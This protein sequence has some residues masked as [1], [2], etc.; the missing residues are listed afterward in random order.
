[1]L[2][3]L[4][5]FSLKLRLHHHPLQGN[6][7]LLQAVSGHLCASLCHSPATPRCHR[8]LEPQSF[9]PVEAPE[10]RS[11]L[12]HPCVPKCWTMVLSITAR[13]HLLPT[14]RLLLGTAG[15]CRPTARELAE[16]PASSTIIWSHRTQEAQGRGVSP[17]LS[18]VSPGQGEE[19]QHQGP[20]PAAAEH[21]T[22]FE[23]SNHSK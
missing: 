10:D 23:F 6:H 11:S 18:Q 17:R 5:K 19:P 3:N 12:T 1:M 14:R 15:T 21:Q 22:G 9:Y 13:C 8:G 20:C 2:S 7:P 16:D 4:E